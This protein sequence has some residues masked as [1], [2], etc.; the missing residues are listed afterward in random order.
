MGVE[1]VS[2]LTSEIISSRIIPGEII[3]LGIIP[4]KKVSKVSLQR[5]R[6]TLG[7][8]EAQ[9]SQVFTGV[10]PIFRETRIDALLY[11]GKTVFK[12]VQECGCFHFMSSCRFSSR[13]R[14]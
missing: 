6:V 2:R 1:G 13:E 5:L 12:S 10:F 9:A 14:F 11:A 4:L 7:E 8:Q 3:L